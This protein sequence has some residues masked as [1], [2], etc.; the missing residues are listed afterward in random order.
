MTTTIIS[1]GVV[2][3]LL[4]TSMGLLLSRD[5]RWSLGL[6]AAQYLGMFWLVTLHWPFGLASVK[7]VT[8]WMASATLG[9]TRLNVSDRDTASESAWPQ[10]RLFRIF[11]AALVVILV[12]AMTPNVETMIPGISR[13]V[14]A[15]GLL[16]AGMGL[17]H[18]GIT[19]ESLRITLGLLTVMAGFEI[20]YATVETS[21]LLAGLLA[22]VNLGLALA[23]AY[24][25]TAIPPEEDEA[26]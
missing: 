8:G 25:M 9:V 22:I 3:L 1:W 18:L 26:E 24:L 10:G 14:I 17:L 23:G 6:L 20:L 21:I 16:L 19:A 5:W 15:G 2:G 7:L 12:I 4:V 13:P 11:A